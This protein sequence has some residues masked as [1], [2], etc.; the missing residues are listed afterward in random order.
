MKKLILMA[1]A[2]LMSLGASAQLIS[3]NTV[4][5]KKGSGYNRLG[6]SYNSLKFGEMDAQNGISLAWTKGISVSASQPLF[7]ETGIGATYGFGDYG[8]KTLHATVP[9]NVTYRYEISD[10]IRIAPLA[11][12]TFAGNIIGEDDEDNYFDDFD[13]KRFTFGWQIGT[14]FEISKFYVGITYG[15]G[16]TDYVEGAKQKMLSA[17]LGLVF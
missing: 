8:F 13:A 9:L 7:I 10:G 11:G 14:N 6:I 4:T 15:A 12:I 3:S 1:V 17:T 16:F 5:Y 2:A